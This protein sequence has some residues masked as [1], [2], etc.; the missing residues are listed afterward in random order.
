MCSK[1]LNTK[2]TIYSSQEFS[3]LDNLRNGNK[4][5]GKNS[6]QCGTKHR[7]IKGRG[8]SRIQ[9]IKMCICNTTN[10]YL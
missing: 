10:V 4:S 8:C 5:N 7:T 6:K 2:M 3:Q 1:R 9:L